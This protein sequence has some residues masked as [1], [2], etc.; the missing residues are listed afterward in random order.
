MMRDNES[1]I[2]YDLLQ[3]AVEAAAPALTPSALRE[4]FGLAASWQIRPGQL[5]RAAWNNVTLLVLIVSVAEETVTAAPATIEPPA[6]DENSLI[7]DSRRTAL[8]EPITVW[9]GLRRQLGLD[10]LD[11]PIDSIGAD[12]AAWVTGESSVPSGCRAGIEPAS[13]FD[14]D[15]E[16]R[17]MAA[18]DMDYLASAQNWAAALDYAP[19]AGPGATVSPSRH[20]LVE[21]QQRLGF[22]LPDVLALVDGTRPATAQGEV[23]ALLEVLGHVPHVRAPARGL[24]TELSHPRWRPAA[25]AFARRGGRSE[26]EA[27]LAMAY[28]ISGASMAARQTGDQDPAWRDRV[29]RWVQAQGLEDA[30]R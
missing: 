30:G 15:I 14:A 27:R 1:G 22:T 24:V 11:R 2:P 23:T 26:S 3:A 5:W 19:A 12:V 25:R 13:P 17:A 6:E 20:Q 7:V 29:Q 9:G 28:E 4:R 21:L 18:D 10:V 16:V 8:N